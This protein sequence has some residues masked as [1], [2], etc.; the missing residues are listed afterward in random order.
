MTSIEV[1]PIANA[2][3]QEL[4]GPYPF[5]WFMEPW[6]WLDR[7]L[8][9]A[10]ER[11]CSKSLKTGDAEPLHSAHE[12]YQIVLLGQMKILDGHLMLVDRLGD[13][14]DLPPGE[15]RKRMLEVRDDFQKHYDSLFPRWQTLEDLAG[16]LLERITPSNDRLKELAQKYPPPQSWSD[17][18]ASL[19][20][21]GA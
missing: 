19:T 12:D 21:R 8:I 16:I 18:P 13:D 5:L 9:D 11:A 20:S 14:Y 10:W 17:E 15:I 6:F 2:M 4:F 3:L 1:I 7:H